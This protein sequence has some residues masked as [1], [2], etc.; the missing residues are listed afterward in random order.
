MMA[1]FDIA[2]LRYL[3][4]AV[5]ITVAIALQFVPLWQKRLDPLAKRYPILKLVGYRVFQLVAGFGLLTMGI[6]LLRL[7]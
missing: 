5:L 2:A 3:V 6:E 7:E 1:L 4:S